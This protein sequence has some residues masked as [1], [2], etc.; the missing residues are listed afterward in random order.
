MALAK[1]QLT[2][3]ESFCSTGFVRVRLF[4]AGSCTLISWLPVRLDDVS[5]SSFG[6]R[7]GPAIKVPRRRGAASASVAA[8]KAWL[9]VTRNFLGRSRTF[10]PNLLALRLS[11]VRLYCL[12]DKQ[13]EN[14]GMTT[15]TT[16]AISTFGFHSALRAK[17]TGK[18][19][20]RIKASRVKMIMRH[21]RKRSSEGRRC[22]LDYLCKH[23]ISIMIPVS[24]FEGQ[25][26]SAIGLG[27]VRRRRSTHLLTLGG[28]RVRIRKSETM[29]RKCVG[30]LL[31][32]GDRFHRGPSIA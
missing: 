9:S 5:A 1:L 3:S 27:N 8:Q 16:Q 32:G 15:N 20:Q 22:K 14:R 23:E 6:P 29:R 17:L 24:E 25:S 13:I 4:L 30:T 11:F 19:S 26:V 10:I 21:N 2:A 28:W 31:V 12:S 7:G 18:L